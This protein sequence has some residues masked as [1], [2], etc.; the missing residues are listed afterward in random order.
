ML[1]NYRGL[2]TDSKIAAFS[3]GPTSPSTPASPTVIEMPASLV[4]GI[5]RSAIELRAAAPSWLVGLVAETLQHVRILPESRAVDAAHIRV[6]MLIAVV[7]A[8]QN[9]SDE[10]VTVEQ[11]AALTGR[12]KET[13]RR[14]V[15]NGTLPSKRNGQRGHHRVRRGDLHL[16]EEKRRMKYDV[17]ADAQDI[18]KRRLGA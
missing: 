6:S 17:A 4:D 9:W 1:P 11:A 12:C 15:R 14:S 8:E 18:V 5:G 10:E 7:T 13:I 2:G 3:D 16:V